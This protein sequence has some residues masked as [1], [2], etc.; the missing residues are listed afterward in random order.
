MKISAALLDLV[1]SFFAH[2]QLPPAV[3][4]LTALT[5]R[6]AAMVLA[7]LWLVVLLCL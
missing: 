7:A 5:E 1:G 3:V 4:Q 2:L 6:H